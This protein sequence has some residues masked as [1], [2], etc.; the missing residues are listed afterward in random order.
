MSEVESGAASEGTAENT[1]VESQEQQTQKQGEHKPADSVNEVLK[2]KFQFKIDGQDFEEEYDLNDT[3]R[4][5]S[6]LQLAK[7]AKKRMFE[8]KEAT[9]KANE[10]TQMFE[11]DPISLFK[12][13]GP[14][15]RELAEQFLLGELQQE[16][17][18]PE[19]KKMREYERKLKEYEEREKTEKEKYEQSVLEQSKAKYIKTF[20]KTIIDALDKSELPKTPEMIADMARLYKKNLELGLELTADE[21]AIES[22][23]EKIQLIKSLFGKSEANQILALMGDDLATKIRKSDIAKIR[24]KQ[25]ML[26]KEPKR[27]E[28]KQNPRSESKTKSMDD[29]KR[30]LDERVKNLQD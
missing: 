5:R 21:L 3:E 16:M 6:E 12:Q 20:Q 14:K 13:L 18:S 1:S 30:E 8:A 7:A 29:W 26:A 27:E 15:G 9:R 4:I 2:R 25:K 23:N 10:L 19:E 28:Y 22:K 24:E 11:K 17:L